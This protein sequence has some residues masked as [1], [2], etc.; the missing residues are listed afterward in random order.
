MQTTPTTIKRD[1]EIDIN[2]RSFQALYPLLRITLRKFD[3]D[4]ILK[5]SHIQHSQRPAP[6]TL[7][8]ICTDADPQ[9]LIVCVAIKL[10]A[11]IY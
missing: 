11:R 10:P 9:L 8:L 1:G 5:A 6:T 2:Q 3:S 4:F 7:V